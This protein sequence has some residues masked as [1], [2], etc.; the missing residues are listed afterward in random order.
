MK[1]NREE[2]LPYPQPW[3]FILSKISG[4]KENGFFVDVGANDGLIVSNT[5]HLEINLN[6]RGICIEPHPEA[7]ER[8]SKNRNC[9]KINCCISNQ[10]TELDFMVVKGYAEM[11]SGLV[12]E[13]TDSQL[14]RIKSETSI[15]GGSTEII[16]VP[17]KTLNSILQDNNIINIDYLSIDT[18]GSEFNVLQ[19]LDLEKYKVKIISVENSGNGQIILNYLKQYNYNFIQN[20]CG[21]DIF[22][23]DI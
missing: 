22:I 18:E 5:A 8:L 11:L 10:E 7:F 13:Y 16:K 19:S 2:S 23:K 6:W 4:R 9:L 15:H 20:I 14:N 1:Y 12:N 3:E 17:S 21:D